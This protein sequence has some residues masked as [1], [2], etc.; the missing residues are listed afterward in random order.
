ML[1]IDAHIAIADRAVGCRN[2]RPFIVGGGVGPGGSEGESE[3]DREYEGEDDTR[4]ALHE[5][6]E[7]MHR[8]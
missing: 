7:L 6:E 5:L 1:V 2:M 4:M 3:E 8:F